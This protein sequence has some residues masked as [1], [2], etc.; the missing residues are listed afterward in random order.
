MYQNRQQ[1]KIMDKLVFYGNKPHA[2]IVQ[3]WSHGCTVK[4]IYHTSTPKKFANN[5]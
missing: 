4:L 1:F 5:A 3:A 2:C